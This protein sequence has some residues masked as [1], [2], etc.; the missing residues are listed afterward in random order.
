MANDP[1]AVAVA[2]S[3]RLYSKAPTPTTWA[4]RVRNAASA[5]SQTAAII[6]GTPTR[7]RL[8]SAVITE[9]P[10]S[11]NLYGDGHEHRDDDDGG[12]GDAEPVAILACQMQSR[13][14]GVHGSRDL[15]GRVDAL[16]AWPAA[17]CGGSAGEG[18]PVMSTAGLRAVECS[19]SSDGSSNES[20][21]L[22]RSFRRS[23]TRTT[24]PIAG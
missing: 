22:S 20:V 15:C 8:G 3:T 23:G 4:S 17:L 21:P 12:I 6:T 24:G 5:P 14:S 10:T 11:A 2:F 1:N 13:G 7:S 18:R 16:A 19:G 9:P